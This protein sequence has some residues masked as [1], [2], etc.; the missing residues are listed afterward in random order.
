M[1]LVGPI[2]GLENARENAALLEDKLPSDIMVRINEF[3]ELPDRVRLASSSK[4]LQK[5][6]FQECTPLWRDI[7]FS[8]VQ[9]E[10]KKNLTDGMLTILL[11]RVNARTVT[12]SLN[13]DDCESLRGTG[14]APLT[15]STSLETIDLRQHS[16]A[17]E[18]DLLTHFLRTMIPYK[19][20]HVALRDA[21][22]EFFRDDEFFHNVE[23]AFISF[24]RDLRAARYRDARDERITC[25][26]CREA[27][28]EESMQMVAGFCG[29]RSTCCGTCRN[30]YCRRGSC[31]TVITDCTGCGEVSCDDCAQCKLCVECNETHCPACVP[32]FTCSGCSKGYCQDCLENTVYVGFC[33]MCDKAVCYSC[34]DEQERPSLRL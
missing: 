11:L 33:S 2:D 22:D 7:D 4:R 9:K 32:V 20:R 23:D 21:C 3:L 28:A 6:I 17:L 5:L 1:V 13:L 16:D 24:L 10:G 31:T 8:K 27:V 30:H 26:T 19:L 12:K 29:I 15:C 34:S 25:N 18:Q 14:L